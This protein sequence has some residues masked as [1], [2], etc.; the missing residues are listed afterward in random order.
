M[1]IK[2]SSDN[3]GRLTEAASAY[4][5]ETGTTAISA[6]SVR[7]KIWHEIAVQAGVPPRKIS[8]R[9]LS[10]GHCG[11]FCLTAGYPVLFPAL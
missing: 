5:W 2:S 3:A 11:R 4:L 9:L 8:V 7:G 6:S 10:G 1:S